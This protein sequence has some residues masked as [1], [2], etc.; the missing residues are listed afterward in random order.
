MSGL[1]GSREVKVSTPLGDDV[2]LFQRMTATEHMGRLFEYQLD[3]VSRNANINLDDLLG[4]N[5][6]VNLKMDGNESRY[7]NGFVSR[8]CFVGLTENYY[9]YQIT[10]KPW[11]WFLTRT[12]DCRIFQKQKV[13]DIIKQV[14]RDQGFSDFEER[15]SDTYREWEYCVQYRETDFNFISRLMEQ[16]GMYY[17]FTHEDGKHTMVLADSIEAHEA[18]PDYEEVPYYPPEETMRRERDHIFDWFVAQEVQPGTY[19]LNDFDFE[20]PKADLNAKLKQSYGHSAD[21][22]EVYDYPGEY[23]EKSDGDEYVRKRIEELHAQYEQVQG[24]GNARGLYVGGLFSLTQYPRDDQ[25]KEYLITSA[26]YEL[27]SDEYGSVSSTTAEQIFTCS[28]T[29]IDSVQPYRA[30]RITPKPVVQGPQTAIVVG[31]SGQEI[32][33][34]KHGRVKVQFHWDREGASDENSSC[35][36]RVSHPTAGKGWGAVQI[37]RIGQEVIVDFLEGDPDRPIITGRV[38]NANSMPPYDLPNQ[39]MVAGMKSNSTPGGGGY[40][41]MIMDDTK[42]NELIRIHAQYNMDSTIEHD[43]TWTINNNRTTTVAV[44]DSE[45]VGSN[46]TISVGSNQSTT[47]GSNQS[48]SV[49][50]N[51][52]EN[53]A[54]AK[55]MA[56]GAAYQVS[57]GAAMNETVGAAK[58]EEI[59]ANK[60]VNVGA[61]S[62]ETVG[63]NKSLDAGENI[64]EAAGKDIS[65][66]S[67]KKMIFAAGDDFGLKG[68]KKGVIEMA[69][70]LTIKVGKATIAM[71]KNGDISINGK[72]ITIKGSGDVAIKGSKI[73]QN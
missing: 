63:K 2:L 30:P 1:Q 32:Y 3:V 45:T 65:V 18:A 54:A 61:S 21:D 37:P 51:K 44:N 17:Y 49:G 10:L 73:T 14:F 22:Y 41:E 34:E 43:Q 64:T 5:V 50:A 69:D 8:F 25:N 4:Q 53:V 56:I 67:G 7:F 28:F 59:G 46:Q 36:I 19:A 70:E 24:R 48:I 9:S 31:P 55:S 52:S 16:E 72:K 15:L 29:A 38:Y 27:Q 13:P 12:A 33:T 20:K 42:G 57:V 11:L 47:V 62:S 60:S 68:D 39:D 58:A 23:L 26:T 6:T 40:N 71:K 35:W 66:Q